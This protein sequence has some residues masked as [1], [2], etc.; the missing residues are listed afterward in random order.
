[1][2][3]RAE[4]LV[5]NSADDVAEALAARLMSRLVELQRDARTP[6]VGL[7]GGRIATKAY[8][9][10]LGGAAPPSTGVP[11]GCGGAT[12]ASSPRTTPTATPVRPWRACRHF[13]STWP[14]STRCRRPATG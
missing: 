1:M 4:I 11:S 8:R 5:H 6:Q 13:R 9:A 3:S 12:S 2:A 7:T 10:G 14:G